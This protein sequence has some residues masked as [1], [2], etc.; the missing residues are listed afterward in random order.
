MNKVHILSCRATLLW[1]LKK[2]RL[3]RFQVRKRKGQ[4]SPDWPSQHFSCKGGCTCH[5]PQVSHN[6]SASLCHTCTQPV[7]EAVQEKSRQ[8][9]Y[10]YMES[11]T[12]SLEEEGNE[13]TSLCCREFL[14]A[15]T[16]SGLSAV[17]IH[18]FLVASY[19][20]L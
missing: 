15:L 10:I 14:A 2:C 11:K 8:M 1:T 7:G 17:Q 16:K 9:C 19:F 20:F 18:L 6:P 12:Q 5:Q 13:L 4:N 3:L